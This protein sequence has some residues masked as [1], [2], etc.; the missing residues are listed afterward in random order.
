M[1]FIKGAVMGFESLSGLLG[2]VEVRAD[3][4]I[5][6]EEVFRNETMSRGAAL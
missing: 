3:L 4:K 6:L 2:R 1:L 5:G